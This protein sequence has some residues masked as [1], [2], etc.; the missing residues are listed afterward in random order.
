MV[1]TTPHDRSARGFFSALYDFSFHSLVTP[2]IIRVLYAIALAGLALFCVLFLINGFR[3][4]YG[5]FGPSAPTP[6]GILLHVL[7]AP[8]LFVLGSIA[9]RIYLELVIVVFNIADNTARRS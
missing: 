2:K 9:A 8:V 6:G 3:P 4:S 7:G 5:L 1:E